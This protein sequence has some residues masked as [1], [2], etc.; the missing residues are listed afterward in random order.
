VVEP[1][2]RADQIPE[3]RPPPQARQRRRQHLAVERV[4]HLHRPAGVAV[5]DLDQAPS[6]Q[7]LDVGRV[8]DPLGGL[9]RYLLAHGDHLQRAPPAGLQQAEALLDQLPQPVLGP[10]GRQDD[11]A[12]AAGFPAFERRGHQLPDEQRVAPAEP[13]DPV[14]QGGRNGLAQDGEH[15]RLRRVAAQG[16]DVDPGQQLVLPQ[17]DQA[18][19]ERL[20]GPHADQ[21]P[22]VGLRG[23]EVQQRHRDLVE[24]VGVVHGQQEAV[25]ASPLVQPRQ[26]QVEEVLPLVGL[27]ARRQQVGERP[28]RDLPGRLGGPHPL[29]GDALVLA[30]TD[31][32]GDEAGLPHSRIPEDRRTPRPPTG[33]Q[34]LVE[35]RELA[36]PADQ[37]PACDHEPRCYPGPCHRFRETGRST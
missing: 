18:Q 1:L 28:E 2:D 25:P 3:D 19:R 21:H 31:R 20:P 33:T 4:G 6:F 30:R 24:E 9:Q 8:G 35:I 27:V 17:P 26:R 12:P 13:P 5:D 15:Q 10:T 16:P 23:R 32:L 14:Q 36:V 29:D 11:P 34:Q 22:D 37:R 7:R